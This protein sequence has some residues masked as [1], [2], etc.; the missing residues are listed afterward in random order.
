MLR[1]MMLMTIMMVMVWKFRNLAMRIMMRILVVMIKV[2]KM[3]KLENMV[4]TVTVVLVMKMI[5]STM[6][7][8]MRVII[9]RT[10]ILSSWPWLNMA[11][12]RV[13]EGWLLGVS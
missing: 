8:T 7:S 13:Q 3:L 12:T 11:T 9:I 4:K 10:R 6:M 2:P 1:E 5:A